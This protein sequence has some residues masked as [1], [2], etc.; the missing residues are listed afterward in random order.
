MTDIVIVGCGGFGREVHDLVDD[1]RATGERLRVLGYVDDSPSE[2][3][4]EL[5]AKRGTP[6]LGGL[7]WFDTAGR[8]ARYVIGIGNPAVCRTI[9]ER[10]SA[11]GVGPATLVHPTATVGY[12]A[13]LAE[14]VV[15]CAGARVSTNVS[16][17][18]HVHA[19]HNAVIEH[20]SVLEEYVIALPL[21]ALGGGVHVG[22][23]ALLGTNC[24]VTRGVRVDPEARIQPGELYDG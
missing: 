15:I 19:H 17:G 13:T 7:D 21:A 8:A 14:G 2:Q 11:T 10:L 23:G 24:T 20:D 1:L 18:R 6:V 9:D 12:A 22:A 5:A 4:R 16:L 3:M